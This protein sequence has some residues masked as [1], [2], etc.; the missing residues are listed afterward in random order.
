MNFK[1]MK[2]KHG[3]KFRIHDLRQTFATD[4]LDKGIT[5]N[6][7]QR[8]LGHAKASTTADIQTHVKPAFE[9]KE[10]A[11]FNKK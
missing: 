4:C 9:N 2:K 3:L 11:K 10:I 1:R 5:I 8:W 6:T 7:V